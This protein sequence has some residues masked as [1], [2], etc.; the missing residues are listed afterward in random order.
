V[1]EGRGRRHLVETLTA[2]G[3]IFVIIL[4]EFDKH[5]YTFGLESSLETTLDLASTVVS[6]SASVFYTPL[7]WMS[8]AI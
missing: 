3:G 2:H 1:G 6:Y 5:T 8:L 4:G 7:D